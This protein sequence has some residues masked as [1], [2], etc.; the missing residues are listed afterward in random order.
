MK[1]RKGKAHVGAMKASKH[2]PR[3]MLPGTKGAKAASTASTSRATAVPVTAASPSGPAV[4]KVHAQG[5]GHKRSRSSSSRV[6][7][8]DK[9]GGAPVL[10]DATTDR[11]TTAMIYRV[12]CSHSQLNASASG[13]NS[14]P[15]PP[16]QLLPPLTSSNKVDLQLYA[17]LAI[18]VKEYI[19]SW[20]SK[21]TPDHTFTD[22]IVKLFAHCTRAVEQR[23][24]KVD[25]DTLLL[26]DLPALIESHVRGEFHQPYINSVMHG[27]MN[28]RRGGNN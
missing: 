26:N 27:G 22:E 21:I 23:L 13:V 20:Y 15:R 6:H 7:R 24:R 2:S 14:P 8:Y 4:S 18:I 12:L 10:L 1:K 5:Q 19:N 9:T 16:E 11:A 28:G 17:L 25:I 3:V